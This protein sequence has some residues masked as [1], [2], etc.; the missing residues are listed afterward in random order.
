MNDSHKLPAFS[1]DLQLNPTAILARIHKAHSYCALPLCAPH[2]ACPSKSP[3]TYNR[4]LLRRFSGYPAF[5]TETTCLQ[6]KQKILAN[7]RTTA[8]FPLPDY[9]GIPTKRDSSLTS[10]TSQKACRKKMDFATTSV[11]KALL[12]EP[13]LLFEVQ[14]FCP[15]QTSAD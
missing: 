3:L 15:L 13:P 5:V 8:A 10:C 7:F 6:R 11:R 2:L 14:R 4:K 1:E 9:C 12:G